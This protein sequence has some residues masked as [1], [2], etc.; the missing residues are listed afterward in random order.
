MLRRILLALAEQKWL[1]RLIVANPVFRRMAF[2]FVAG[3]SLDDALAAV[4]RLNEMGAMATLDC[5][6]ENV[7]SAAEAGEARDEYLR[8][9][10]RIAAEGLDCNVS[11]KLTQM[12][13]DLD[14]DLC[15]DHMRSILEK[16]EEH[17]NFVRLD[18]EG[19]SYTGGT[20]DIH[21]RLWQEHRNV[22]VVIQSYLYRSSADV[23]RV[24][25]LG[26]RVRL[27]KGAYNE[28]GAVAFPRKSD[29]D[30]SYRI[31]AQKLLHAG[32][33]PGF[34][35]HDV[36]IVDHVK[37]LARTEGIEPSRYEFQMLY[38]IRRDLQ[39]RLVDEG[40]RVRV[41]VPY[42]S[43]WYP[44]FMRRLAERPAN[45]VFFLSSLLR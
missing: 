15:H 2:R 19:S 17:G 6:G 42:G 44:Y 45:V 11:L 38:G 30:A 4:R 31:L 21:E 27:C 18:M 22:G 32:H 40:Y 41:Y 13:Y 43:H 9:L 26:A 24:N 20:L 5:L 34:A 29:T 10:D 12:G 33:Y 3:E 14:R 23:D 37:F 16:A 1:Y 35:T 28:S 25:R 8:A 36:R 7:H 39:Q